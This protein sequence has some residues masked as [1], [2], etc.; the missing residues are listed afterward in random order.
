IETEKTLKP[1]EQFVYKAPHPSWPPIGAQVG[2]HRCPILRQDL[3]IEAAACSNSGRLDRLMML[4]PD[5]DSLDFAS[6]A[7]SQHQHECWATCVSSCSFA[8][9]ALIRSSSRLQ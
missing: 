9:R 1:S 5:T 8:C 2:S 7:I 4:G 3:D 6:H